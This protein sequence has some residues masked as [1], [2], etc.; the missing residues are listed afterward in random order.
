M[1]LFLLETYI[2]FAIQHGKGKEK[3]KASNFYSV[4]HKI[5]QK[6]LKCMLL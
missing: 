5:K 6:P 2:Y 4:F 1:K 3:E